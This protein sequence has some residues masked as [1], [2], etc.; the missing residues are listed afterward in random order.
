[1][2]LLRWFF[3][4]VKVTLQNLQKNRESVLELIAHIRRIPMLIQQIGEYK[5]FEKQLAAETRG[6]QISQAQN[7]VDLLTEVKML[8]HDIGYVARFALP[9]FPQKEGE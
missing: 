4:P 5:K 9:A 7:L 6:I 3:K 1:M 2:F 8:R